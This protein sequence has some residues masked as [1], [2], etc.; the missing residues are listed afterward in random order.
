M[1]NV[2]QNRMNSCNTGLNTFEKHQA[3][4]LLIK[5]MLGKDKFALIAET[6]LPFFKIW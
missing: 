1:N 2:V 5:T 6:P 4:Y 3:P